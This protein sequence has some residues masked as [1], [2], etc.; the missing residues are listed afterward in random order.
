[1]EG[2]RNENDERFQRKPRGKPPVTRLHAPLDPRCRARIKGELYNSATVWPSGDAPS[3]SFRR[4]AGLSAGSCLPS[5]WMEDPDNET[6]ATAAAGPVCAHFEHSMLQALHRART[7]VASDRCAPCT[8]GG[9]HG[10]GGRLSVVR[11]QHSGRYHKM[12]A[13]AAPR[14]SHRGAPHV[15]RP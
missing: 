1:M 3:M 7:T 6:G 9:G 13:S 15:R 11:E 8:G 10:G 2:E 14:G 12:A 4:G 5:V